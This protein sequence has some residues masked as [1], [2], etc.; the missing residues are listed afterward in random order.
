MT[1]SGQSIQELNY[2]NNT[3]V[4]TQTYDDQAAYTATVTPS[5]TVVPPGTPVVL[6]GVATMASNGAPAAQVPVAVEIQV[7]GTTRT[8]TATTDANGNYSVTF[9]P[10]PRRGGRLLGHGRRPGRHQP[11]GAGA[12]RDRRHDGFP[13]PPRA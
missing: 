13:M 5:A 3:G 9:Q 1:D 4:A 2:S 8:L 7:A 11:R 6:S 12:V 10:L